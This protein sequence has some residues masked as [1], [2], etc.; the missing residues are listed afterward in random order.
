MLTIILLDKVFVINPN[1]Q[2]QGDYHKK[3][4]IALSMTAGNRKRA[5]STWLPLEIMDH[6]H[7]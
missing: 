4:C 2:G 5:N 6:G 3:L 1:N 7:T